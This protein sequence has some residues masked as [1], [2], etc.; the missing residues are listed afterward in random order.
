VRQAARHPARCL[1]RTEKGLYTMPYTAEKP[2]HTPSAERL[3]STIAGWGVDLDPANRP[4]VPKEQFD[5]AATGAHWDFPERQIER[6]PRER[7]VEHRF[8][9]PVFGTS[10]PP[11]GMSGLIRR[12]AYRFSEGRMLH[13]TLLVLADRVDVAES[14]LLSLAQGRPDNTFRETGIRAELDRHGWSSR[15]GQRRADLVHQPIDAARFIVPGVLAMGALFLLARG[16]RRPPADFASWRPARQRELEPAPRRPRV[17]RPAPH[18][19][20]HNADTQPA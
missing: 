16:R 4:A 10:C 8:L 1:I 18:P 5:L 20:A 11:R 2:N 14:R 15:V 19:L 12:Y 7:S 9:T 3:R 17:P 6:Y 13:W